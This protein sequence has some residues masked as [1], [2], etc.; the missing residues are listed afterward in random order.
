MSPQSDCYNLD[1]VRTSGSGCS[2]LVVHAN[3]RHRHCHDINDVIKE[4]PWCNLHGGEIFW[5]TETDF[6]VYSQG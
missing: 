3:H 6:G 5:P 2:A 1:P 4:V